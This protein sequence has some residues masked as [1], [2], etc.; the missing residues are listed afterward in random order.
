M[1]TPYHGCAPPQGPCAR[2]C[3][4]F[5]GG[6]VP[7]PSLTPQAD[8]RAGLCSPYS[9]PHPV[10]TGFALVSLVVLSALFGLQPWSSWSSSFFLSSFF[11]FQFY[12]H[13]PDV[14][15]CVSVRCTACVGIHVSQNDHH[16]TF[17]EHPS[18]HIVTKKHVLFHVLR[19]CK[20]YLLATFKYSSEHWHRAPPRMP[21]T[22][23][24]SNWASTPS[25][26]LYPAIP[27]PSASGHQVWFLRCHVSV[28]PAEFIRFRPCPSLWTL[29][30]AQSSLL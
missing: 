9:R 29:M 18:P 13:E 25:V 8:G 20:I 10:P 28:A 11:L 19:T 14:Q 24:A 27:W 7:P 12:W 21:R 5:N 16:S 6:C 26:P 4:C 1:Q 22:H 30:S 17:S 2:V 3:S 15:L 23:S